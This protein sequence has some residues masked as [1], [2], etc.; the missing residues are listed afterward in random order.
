[1]RNRTQ[2]IINLF[3]LTLGIACVVLIALFINSE[4]RYDRH[5]EDTDRIF[6]VNTNGKMGEEEF[7]AGY[8]PPPLGKALL[9]DFPE[10]ESYTRIY[11][12]S[13]KII[14]TVN[15][16]RQQLQ[17]IENGILSVD[18][19]FL[20][21]LAYPLQA[22]VRSTCLTDPHSI[23]LTDHM[24][25]KYFGTADPIGKRLLI[26]GTNRPYTV[27]AIVSNTRYP[28]SLTFDIL[29]P[30]ANSE[31]VRYFDWSWVWINMATYIKL[32]EHVPTDAEAIKHLESKFPDMIRRRAASA[33]DRIGQPY[34]EFLERGN[35]WA[36]SLQPLL[37]IHL[38]SADII[39]VITDQGGIKTVYF[40]AIIALF[41]LLLACVNFMNL[42]TAGA[43]GRVKEIGVR[44]VM[45]SGRRGVARQFYLEALAMSTL[46]CLLGLV[47][48]YAAIPYFNQLA[49]KSI[50]FGTLWANG[51][52][53][54]IILL[55]LVCT[56][57]AGSYPALYLSSFKPVTILRGKKI[58]TGFANS[59]GTRNGLIV[60]QFSISIAL[61][62]C[63]M[64]VYQQLQYAQRRDL[65]L[66][67]E[68]VLVI[69]NSNRLGNQEHSFREAL[70]NLSAIKNA[71]ATTSLPGRGAFGDFYVPL[72]SAGDKPVVED[73]TLNSYL[74]D[75]NF[76]PT[77]GV[78]LI[79]GRN[80]TKGFNDTRTV[81]INETAAKRM[82]YKNPIGK[83][84]KYPGG[85]AAESYQIIGIIKDFH[86]ESLHSLIQP[87]ALFHESSQ[88]Y[89]IPFS[90]IAVRIAPGDVPTVLKEI[91]DL[92]KSFAPNIPF[93]YSFLREE[94]AMQYEADQRV[95]KIIGVFSTL[96]IVIACIGL[97]GLVIFATQRRTKEIGIRKVLGATE[98][99]IVC[100]LSK[101]FIK[102][103][104]LAIVI[105]SPLAWWVMNQWLQ[106]F[107]YRIDIEW[108]M[109]AASG[110][111]AVTIAMATVSFQ[112]IRA[113]VA[114][115]A[116]SLR[117]E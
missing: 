1:M 114:N 21:L 51:N 68:N 42:S 15:D 72:A 33:F 97:L 44:K 116:E 98:G 101:D 84:I 19:N 25:K 82:G 23:V 92:W 99:S 57:L 32:K 37:D 7:L 3:G 89:D 112:A 41:I 50:D 104:C 59:K 109:F 78:S 65:G 17:F 62:I 70:K 13:Q 48:A 103:V 64:V 11:R 38:H 73:I 39:S 6:R 88:S 74:T 49:G 56:G 52:W 16:N 54:F 60:F 95:A 53:G 34:D 71:S 12:P 69:S 45:G 110:L 81:L 93:E 75:H 96:S 61:I 28:S 67:S 107:A 94:L 102:L 10:I 46:A 117:D 105:A 29:I 30:V 106:D 111:A 90:N 14:K 40:F 86:T 47:L 113:A 2:T 35:R 91:G 55:V 22:G 4:L 43:I 63:T 100:L 27:T 108:W 18:S 20:E 5:F 83:F 77:L 24:A 76:L 87:F 80:F 8:T 31:D 66:D 115:P 58:P 26:E 79:S 9:E 85:D 36:F